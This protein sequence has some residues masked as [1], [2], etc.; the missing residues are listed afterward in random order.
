VDPGQAKSIYLRRNSFWLFVF[1]AI[2]ACVYSGRGDVLHGTL[3]G[4]M[5]LLLLA[6]R[7]RPYKLL[8]TLVGAH[9][10]LCARHGYL[11]A[12]SLSRRSS[13]STSLPSPKARGGAERNGP[14]DTVPSWPPCARTHTRNAAAVHR[15]GLSARM[16]MLRR[17]DPHHH[18]AGTDARPARDSSR[19]RA[20]YLPQ[21]TRVQW[22]ALGCGLAG[23]CRFRPMASHD[24]GLPHAD[25]VAHFCRRPA[26]S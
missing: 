17:S 14:T 22:W 16:L 12:T 5:G 18:V 2:H 4:L 25:P 19:I 21:V 3:C 6:L 9:A 26:T 11:S 7:P 10:A 24:D 23:R 1:G 13:G 8:W 15:A 20:N